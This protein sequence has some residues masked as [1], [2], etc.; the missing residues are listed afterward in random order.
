V[1]YRL[2]RK[3][4]RERA[5]EPDENSIPFKAELPSDAAIAKPQDAV[6]RK[7]LP[8]ATVSPLESDQEETIDQR[9]ARLTA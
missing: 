7:P 9:R 4:R 2:R 5:T 6:S 8:N 3:P 1:G